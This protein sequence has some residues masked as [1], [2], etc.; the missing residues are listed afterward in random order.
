MEKM[1]F[2]STEIKATEENSQKKDTQNLEALK[3][4]FETLEERFQILYHHAQEVR[5]QKLAL[6]RE[7]P[8]YE[9]SDDGEAV[10]INEKYNQIATL[11][12]IDVEEIARLLKEKRRVQQEIAQFD[13][14]KDFYIDRMVNPIENNLN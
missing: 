14:E 1:S 5:D 4:E 2:D 6:E 7:L 3:D 10:I 12:Q 8:K 13:T 11:L 9:G